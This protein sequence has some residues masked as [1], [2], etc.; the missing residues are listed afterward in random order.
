MT[1]RM[2]EGGGWIWTAVLGQRWALPQVMA[3]TA[4]SHVLGLAV[5]IFLMAVYDRVLPAGAAGSLVALGAGVALAVGFDTV[6]RL[7]RARIADA[8]GLAVER[9]ATLAL[10]G[11]L[12]AGMVAPA[13]DE[14]LGALAEAEARRD[15]L[16]AALLTAAGDLPFVALYLLAIWLIAG[17]VV[18]VPVLAL[19]ALA[20][21]AVGLGGRIRTL[22]AADAA[23]GARRRRALGD[24]AAGAET[25]RA[26]AGGAALRTTI[27]RL[28]D[29]QFGR[30]A[31]LR[32]RMQTVVQGGYLAQ[33]AAQVG[34][35]LWGALLV[36][37]ARL[38][39]GALI[40]AVLLTARALGPALSVAQLAGQIVAARGRATPALRPAAPRLAAAA[41]TLAPPDFA[42]EL[43]GVAWAPPG[44][45]APVLR[46][47]S[48]RVAAGERIAL[49]G[50]AAAGKSVLLRLIAGLEQPAEGRVLIDGTDLVRH[51]P[52]RLGRH[53]GV[54]LDPLWLPAGTLREVVAAGRPWI[55]GAALGRAAE[56]AGLGGLIG[57]DPRGWD[58][59]LEAGARDLSAGQRRALGL[60]RAVAGGP[61][62]LLLDDPTSD[63]DPRAEAG[64]ALALDRGA[65]GATMVIVTHRPA[66]MRICDRV[67][68]LDQGR[69]TADV[70]PETYLARAAEAATPAP[71]A[72][73]GRHAHAV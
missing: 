26:M 4:L 16:G 35:V 18:A 72:R 38:S 19:A 39:G 28:A 36:I 48:L 41:E 69:I 56:I 7:L 47:I 65:A 44:A 15:G 53:A 62:L 14:A 58:R 64:L 59:P 8:A 23:A 43:R 21:L 24:L 3:A 57:A 73:T 34:V 10:A 2:S 17:P 12:G 54:V 68:V 70:A 55:E 60:A 37:D 30:R 13:R 5:A 22:A 50:P 45:A 32:A 51:D 29:E 66:M 52:L 11:A 25:L 1:R 63:L 20:A 40:A 31:A 46:A 67:V 42:L 9:E 49:T 6:L 33:Q 27:A 71:A 61:G